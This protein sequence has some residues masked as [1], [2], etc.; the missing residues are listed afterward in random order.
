MAASDT[1][2]SVSSLPVGRRYTSCAVTW[3]STLVGMPTTSVRC[4]RGDP[5]RLLV[6]A[7]VA[8]QGDDVFVGHVDLPRGVELQMY[9]RRPPLA[10][11]YW[12]AAARSRDGAAWPRP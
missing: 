11:R 1:A 2:I 7:G 10:M 3:V 5:D 12:P 9:A 6:T 4:G 8:Q